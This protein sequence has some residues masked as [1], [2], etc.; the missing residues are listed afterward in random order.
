MT[1]KMY[2]DLLLMLWS[3]VGMALLGLAVLAMAWSTRRSAAASRTWPT[4]PGTIIASSIKER[5]GKGGQNYTVQ[6]SYAYRT[7]DKE[8]TGDR[9]QWGI[10]H[11]TQ[12]QAA[13]IVA[14]YPAGQ[15]VTVYYHPQRPQQAVLDP[16]GTVGSESLLMVAA[17]LLL[18]GGGMAAFALFKL[19]GAG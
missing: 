15:P 1:D 2:G 8:H 4:T 18:P 10:P 16:Q 9:I 6:I 5:R 11:H 3:G 12:I 7:G 14:R 17:L 13:G 19:A